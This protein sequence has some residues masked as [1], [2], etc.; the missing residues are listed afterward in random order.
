MERR[1]F[2]AA[3]GVAATPVPALFGA[4]REDFP[5]ASRETY[6]NCATEH[7]L[8]LPAARAMEAYV[9]ALT[10]GP[11]SERERFETPPS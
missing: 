11:D 10:Y 6:L 9:R 2:L 7:P 5:W 3:A 8:P 1:H 4:A